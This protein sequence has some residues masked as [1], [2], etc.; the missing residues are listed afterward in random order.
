MASSPQLKLENQLL[1]RV[2]LIKVLMVL[3][4][5]NDG[6]S[7]LVLKIQYKM[8]NSYWTNLM[9][10]F[11]KSHTKTPLPYVVLINVCTHSSDRKIQGNPRMSSTSHITFKYFKV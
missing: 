5:S 1:G 11:T 10:K 8:E 2:S 9:L 6:W 4:S 7:N 3:K